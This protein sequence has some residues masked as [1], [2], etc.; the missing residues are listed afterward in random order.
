MPEEF[1]DDKEIILLALIGVG[2]NRLSWSKFESVSDRLKNDKEVVLAAVRNNGEAI[3]FASDSLKNEWEIVC[4]AINQSCSLEH[5]SEK[6][7]DDKQIVITAIK[8]NK[9]HSNQIRFASER[10]KNDR[11]VALSA[12]AKCGSDLEYVSSQL[13]KDKE[14][15]LTAVGNNGMA[16]EFASDELKNDAEIVKLAIKGHLNAFN[17]ASKELREN[18]SMLESLYGLVEVV[19]LRDPNHGNDIFE[20][21]ELNLQVWKEDFNESLEYFKAKKACESLGVGWRLPTNFEWKLIYI[22]MYKRGIG[23]L[24]GIY[25]GEYNSEFG[26]YKNMISENRYGCWNTSPSFPSR[27]RAVRSI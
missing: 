27:V 17:F 22:Y 15:V 20:M 14:V 4:E 16:L 8:K 6:F 23:S 21:K 11:E 26:A 9:Y 2:Y 1:K 24:E 10:L 25:W 3:E 19:Q 5:V 7:R 13:K 12:L 18:P